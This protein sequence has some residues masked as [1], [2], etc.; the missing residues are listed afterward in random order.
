M[1]EKNSFNITWTSDVKYFHA[2]FYKLGYKQV[3]G[4]N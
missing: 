2:K 1:F 4:E 3:E